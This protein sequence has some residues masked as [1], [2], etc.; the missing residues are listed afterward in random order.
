MGGVAP[1]ES[2]DERALL[3]QPLGLPAASLAFVLFSL[4]DLVVTALVFRW[5]GYEANVLAAYFLRYYGVK[6]LAI[7]K[8]ALTAGVVVACQVIWHKYP[9]AARVVLL[10][11]CAIYAYVVAAA[12][13]KLY[14]HAAGMPLFW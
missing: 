4:C 5:G 10:G 1:V 8:F 11:G 6:G 7:Y 9:R 3:R 13:L 2:G 14:L 12:S